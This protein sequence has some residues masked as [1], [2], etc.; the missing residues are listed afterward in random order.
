MYNLKMAIVKRRN[1]QFYL[2]YYIIYIPLPTNKFVLDKHI[3]S[4]LVNLHLNT[5]SDKNQRS[6]DIVFRVLFTSP[7]CGL[8]WS[9]SGSSLFVPRGIARLT[10]SLEALCELRGSYITSC[11]TW[12]HLNAAWQNLGILKTRN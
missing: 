8:E 5:V 10:S 7:L 2:M 3:C 9:V 11:P 6:T 12:L 4:I 1:M